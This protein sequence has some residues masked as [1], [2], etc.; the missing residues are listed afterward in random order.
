MDIIKAYDG[1]QALNLAES[2]RPAIIILDMMLPKR[3]GF[4]LLEKV[5]RKD[6]GTRIKPYVIMVTANEGARHQA[7]AEM[8]GVNKYLKKPFN[9][10]Q[11]T[12]EVTT[13]VSV[14]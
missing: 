1:N 4:L 9:M 14:M 12:N 10:E 6:E 11:L 5:R 2:R 7:Y 13:A 3:S 8:L